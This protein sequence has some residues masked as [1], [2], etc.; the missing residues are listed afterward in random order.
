MVMSQELCSYYVLIITDFI[1]LIHVHVVGKIIT[2][3][4]GNVILLMA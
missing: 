2:Y 1:Y 4:I 3:L